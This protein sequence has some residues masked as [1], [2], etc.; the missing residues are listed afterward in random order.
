MKS[1]VMNSWLDKVI[2]VRKN[3]IDALSEKLN[4]LISKH[5]LAVIQHN[6]RNPSASEM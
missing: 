1:N 6:W 3:S 4:K 2:E 5:K